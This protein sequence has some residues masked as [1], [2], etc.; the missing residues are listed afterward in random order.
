MSLLTHDDVW[1]ARRNLKREHCPRPGCNCPTCAASHALRAY[2]RLLT[3]LDFA[4][5]YGPHT[6]GGL[7]GDNWPEQ[8]RKQMEQI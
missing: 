8:L 4:K 3:A 6:L 2:D 1:R 5:M 7:G